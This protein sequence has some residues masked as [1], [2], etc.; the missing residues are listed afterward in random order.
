MY[1]WQDDPMSRRLVRNILILAALLL[2]VYLVIA[3]IGEVNWM[4]KG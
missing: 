4:A 1:R 2:I 3:L